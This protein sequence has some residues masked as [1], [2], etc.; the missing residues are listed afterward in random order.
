MAKIDYYK[1]VID[2]INGLPTLPIIVSKITDLIADPKTV[3]ADIGKAISE[4]QALSSKVLKM[5]NSAYYG[6]PRKITTIS[7]AV[8]IL[9]FSAI[10]NLVL[11]A[12]IVNLFPSDVESD[13]NRD[14]FWSHSIATGIAAR[15]VA[16][17]M[18]LPQLDDA[19]MGGLLHDIGKLVLDQFFHEEFEKI[20]SIV[21][22]KDCLFI[23]AEKEAFEIDMD[24][25]RIGGILGEKW[26]LP[27][28]LVQVVS[29]HHR[30]IYAKDNLKVACIVSFAD[31]IVRAL[32][33]GSGGDHKI[34]KIDDMTWNELGISINMLDKIIK[35]I[36]QELSEANFFLNALK[37][38]D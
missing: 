13:F 8:V 17:R 25:S 30:P 33:V 16:K 36:D 26:N 19:F 38:S 20:I 35:D 37:E 9:G 18:K 6:F 3:A 32:G 11:S 7:Q 27:V 5:V 34:P 2:R 21:K 14:D 28:N 15:A 4:D 12:S 10:R 23:E 31:V 24:H 29:M 22:E 1:S